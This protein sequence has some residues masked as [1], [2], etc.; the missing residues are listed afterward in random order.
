MNAQEPT[1]KPLHWKTRKKLE[2]A[3]AG[4]SVPAQLEP[5]AVSPSCNSPAASRFASVVELAKKG[6]RSFNAHSHT[7]I[8]TF[9]G[10]KQRKFALDHEPTAAEITALADGN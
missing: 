7:L 10:G 5:Q 2:A 3:A 4:G 6:E 9:P 1:G 8:V